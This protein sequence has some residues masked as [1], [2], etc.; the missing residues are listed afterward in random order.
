M[1]AC[2]SMDVLIKRHDVWRRHLMNDNKTT[3][4]Q[5][6][7]LDTYGYPF[8]PSPCK[9]LRKT[10]IRSSKSVLGACIYLLMSII[11]GLLWLARLGKHH[12]PLTPQ[13]FHP[14]RILSIRL[15]LIGALLLS[16]T[17]VPARKRTY[18]DADSAVLDPPDSAQHR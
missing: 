1:Q 9:K 16:L 5:Q 4:R 12:P 13:S 6:N 17:V 2:K 8:P 14:Q 11:G 7:N 3:E 15:D 18:P 10:T